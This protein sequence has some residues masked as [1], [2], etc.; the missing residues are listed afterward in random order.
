MDFYYIEDSYPIGEKQ[1]GLWS[2]GTTYCLGLKYDTVEVSLQ[3]CPEKT[4]DA[5]NN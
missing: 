2:V 5:H 1:A 3:L 4:S